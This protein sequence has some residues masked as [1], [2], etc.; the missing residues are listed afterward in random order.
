MNVQMELWQRLFL[1]LFLISVSVVMK[2]FWW[3]VDYCRHAVNYS[4]ICAEFKGVVNHCS[5]SLNYI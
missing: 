2:I 1:F 5:C 3:A 4:L